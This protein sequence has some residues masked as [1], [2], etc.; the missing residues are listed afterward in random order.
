MEDSRQSLN[1]YRPH[2]ASS[3]HP[4]SNP[5]KVAGRKGFPHVVYSKIFRWPD[6]HKNELKHSG[7]CRAGFDM[8][9]DQLCINPYPYERILGVGS[10]SPTAFA[11]TVT[12]TSAP[13]TDPPTSDKPK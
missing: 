9:T 11:S 3:T 5:V 6:L 2:P 1:L 8:R 4:P 13:S 12:T 7:V 10:I